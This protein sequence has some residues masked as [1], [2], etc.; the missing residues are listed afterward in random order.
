MLTWRG[1]GAV[2]RSATNTISIL[3][4]GVPAAESG[5]IAKDVPVTADV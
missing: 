3:M 5:A 2:H 1:R 4:M